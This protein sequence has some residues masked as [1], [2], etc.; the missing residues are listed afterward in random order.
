MDAINGG[1]VNVINVKGLKR[2]KNQ[3][4]FMTME[5]NIMNVHKDI[6]LEKASQTNYINI[7][8]VFIIAYYTLT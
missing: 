8:M 3:L 4:Q 7:K 2:L 6:V 5:I 1:L